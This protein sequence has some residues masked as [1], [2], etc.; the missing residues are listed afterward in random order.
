MML[1]ARVGYFP[2][3]EAPGTK[4]TRT[5]KAKDRT[6]MELRIKIFVDMAYSP[7]LF[8]TSLDPPLRDSGNL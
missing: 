1:I 7:F 2:C 8:F 4:G 5:Q 3:A 6:T